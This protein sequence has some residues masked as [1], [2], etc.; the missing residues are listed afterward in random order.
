MTTTFMCSHDG[1]A[2]E[3]SAERVRVDDAL[4]TWRVSSRGDVNRFITI[5]NN[6]PGL[7]ARYQYKAF[8]KWTVVE[9][10]YDY[11]RIVSLI[12]NQLEYYIKGLWKPPLKGK[13]E[14]LTA[15]LLQNNAQGKLF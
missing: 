2:F 13:K 1:K 6:R 12:T 14:K 10:D 3:F 11:R 4:E 15:T 9:G 5:T 8:Y 7:H